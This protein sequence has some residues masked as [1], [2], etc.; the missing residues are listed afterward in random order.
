VNVDAC[1]CSRR[2]PG[3]HAVAYAVAAREFGKR[4]A[5]RTS[6][7]SL[8]LQRLGEFRGSA[9]VLAPLLCPA[10]PFGGAGAD[11][12]ALHVGEAS[13]D[14]DHQPPSENVH[15]GCGARPHSSDTFARLAMYARGIWLLL[16]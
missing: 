10:A 4:C 16:Q 14:G 2:Q 6:P 15:A 8:G 9:H 5:L 11:K 3:D 1:S 7:A 12:V 13:E